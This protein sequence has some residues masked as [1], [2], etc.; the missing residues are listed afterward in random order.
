MRNGLPAVAAAAVVVAA[1]AIVTATN[2][3]DEPRCGGFILL[4]SLPGP[5]SGVVWTAMTRSRGVVR[6][7]SCVPRFC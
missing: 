7:P 3:V 4:N 1:V 5:A 6:G 2:G